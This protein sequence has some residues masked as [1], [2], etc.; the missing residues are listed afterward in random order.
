[1]SR[2]CARIGEG[3]LSNVSGGCYDHGAKGRV[4]YNGPLFA[5]VMHWTPPHR[6]ARSMPPMP[7]IVSAAT[8]D[9]QAEAAQQ[10]RLKSAVPMLCWRRSASGIGA[11]A[12]LDRGARGIGRIAWY[13]TL[14]PQSSACRIDSGQ[15]DAD[16]RSQQRGAA[17]RAKAR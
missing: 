3:R 4:Q 13:R 17:G 15:A 16:G 6:W 5:L 9:A 2:V 7:A 1:M 8:I 12:L 10:Q 14:D 11:G